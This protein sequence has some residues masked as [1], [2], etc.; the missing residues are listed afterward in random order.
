MSGLPTPYLQDEDIKRMVRRLATHGEVTQQ[1]AESVARAVHQR[2]GWAGTPVAFDAI[3]KYRPE[4][5]KQ[6][7][8]EV[9]RQVLLMVKAGAGS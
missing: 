9:A 8:I 4:G 1:K 3:G 6:K 5:Q 7:D 2:I